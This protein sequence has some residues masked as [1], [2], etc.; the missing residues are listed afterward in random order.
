MKKVLFLSLFIGGVILALT[1]CFSVDTEEGGEQPLSSA[2][3]DISSVGSSAEKVLVENSS[4]ISNAGSSE[5]H[6]D[7]SNEQCDE[8]IACVPTIGTIVFEYES[9]DTALLIKGNSITQYD[10]TGNVDVM[11]V[12]DETIGQEFGFTEGEG[13]SYE[14]ELPER[15]E[16]EI[17]GVEVVFWDD[18]GRRSYMIPVD[19][20]ADDP[21]V[22]W[23]LLVVKP[24]VFPVEEEFRLGTRE[25]QCR[26]YNYGS[27]PE[28]CEEHCTSSGCSYS[29]ESGDWACDADC[30]G[31]GS[32]VEKRSL[33]LVEL[34]ENRA[35]W[36]RSVGET[37]RRVTYSVF[38]GCNCM[39]ESTG[40]FDVS[41][42]GNAVHRIF[43]TVNEREY[44]SDGSAFMSFD[45]LADVDF[46]QLSVDDLFQEI[47]DEFKR[48]E[49][50]EYIEENSEYKGVEYHSEYGYPVKVNIGPTEV[51]GGLS[52]SID[53]MDIDVDPR[54]ILD[55]IEMAYKEWVYET[56]G[57]ATYTFYRSCFCLIEDT[58]PFIVTIQD[59]EV[60]NVE[61]NG[62]Q[63]I[64]VTV[65]LERYSD[66]SIMELFSDIDSAIED[67]PY[68]F[69][70]NYDKEFPFPIQFNRSMSPMIADAGFS[71]TISDIVQK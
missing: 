19:I 34:Q 47:E 56:G 59:N 38:K 64:V 52:F 51:D 9:G 25:D 69:S 63:K 36:N 17:K 6:D 23:C 3:L 26:S 68:G 57:N 66:F 20:S 32:C 18:N 7:S 2:I 55:S 50:E 48:L 49:S 44:F 54:P 58:G 67:R 60:T 37:A 28:S 35:L 65:D 62:M 30:G 33:A 31:I 41:A 11:Y 5:E 43:N 4:D 70:V 13:E 29:A 10:F 42:A 39:P 22:S 12:S 53:S 61:Y 24:I 15:S 27:C 16:G 46:L 40:P 71:V 1:S 21:C 14:L 8:I 45:G